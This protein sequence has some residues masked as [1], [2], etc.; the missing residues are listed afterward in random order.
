M[1]TEAGEC[2]ISSIVYFYVYYSF[3]LDLYFW[4]KV[5]G[6][7]QLL[8]KEN[9]IICCSCFTVTLANACCTYWEFI[10]CLHH[11]IQ[12][13]Y[14]HRNK[15]NWHTMYNVHCTYNIVFAFIVLLTGLH[16]MCKKSEWKKEGKKQQQTQTNANTRSSKHLV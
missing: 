13:N 14:R 10:V 12:W 1:F 8:A 11:R 6:I 3:C 5:F 2:W 7:V 9:K 16:A 4:Q 15:K